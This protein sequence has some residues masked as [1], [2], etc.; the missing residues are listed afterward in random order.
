MASVSNINPITYARDGYAY[1]DD[2]IGRRIYNGD[3][4]DYI[5]NLGQNSSG[6]RNIY[7]GNGVDGFVYSLIPQLP[8]H[9]ILKQEGAPL[10]V[11]ST[12]DC[13][14][15]DLFALSGFFSLGQDR[16][17]LIEGLTPTKIRCVICNGS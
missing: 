11:L 5:G 12:V 16:V 3:T 7:T 10:Q 4:L 9:K 1:G 17:G 13:P 8:N 14:K 2:D 15:P 6:F